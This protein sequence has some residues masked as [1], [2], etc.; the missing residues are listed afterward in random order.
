MDTTSVP[1]TPLGA[2]WSWSVLGWLW[3]AAAAAVV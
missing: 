1:A 2:Q 3:L